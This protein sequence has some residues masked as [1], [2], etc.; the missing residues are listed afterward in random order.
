MTTLLEEK[1]LESDTPP[2]EVKH[3]YKKDDLDRNLLLGEEIKALCG[4]IKKGLAHPGADLPA[5]EECVKIW[6]TLRD[7]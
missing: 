5:C 1:T 7:E 4:H 3:Y 2:D 6:E